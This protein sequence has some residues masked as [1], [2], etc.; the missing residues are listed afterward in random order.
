MELWKVALFFKLIA[1]VFYIRKFVERWGT[2][3]R[4][5]VDACIA[6][7][8]PEPEFTQSSGGF[9]ITFKFRES[10]SVSESEP[11]LMPA[12]I[13]PRQQEILNILSEKQS[14]SLKEITQLM[15]NNVQ[16]RLVRYDLYA[17]KKL[18]MVNTLGHGR[19]AVWF[20]QE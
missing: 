14:I 18:G 11:S 17:L 10:L 5:M 9:S 1:N 3:I 15:P 13:T 2:G 19:G 20:K 4:K 16:E 12:R 6:A 7:N 8:L